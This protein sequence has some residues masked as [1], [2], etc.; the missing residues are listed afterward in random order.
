MI[1]TRWLAATGPIGILLALA[2]VALAAPATP[3]AP[4]ATPA[5]SPLT[6]PLTE[7]NGDNPPGSQ[8]PG[9]YGNDALWT[10]LTM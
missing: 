10:T 3:V 9:G 2:T 5:I 1:R 6:C 4:A 7:P 8:E